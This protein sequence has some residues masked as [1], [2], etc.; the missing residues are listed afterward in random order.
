METLL[1]ILALAAV[2]LGI[3]T[4]YGS[5]SARIRRALRGA[6]RVSIAEAPEGEVVRID[7]RVAEGE[8]LEAPLT[9]RRCVYY[10]A[11][12]EEKGDAGDWMEVVR[13]SGGVR[14]MVEDGTG[15]AIIDPEGARINVDLDSTTRSGTIDEPTSRETAFLARHRVKGIGLFF[16]RTLRYRE[17]V[18]EIG[19]PI[20]V[21]CQPVRE[22]DPDAASRTAGYRDLPPTRLRVGGSSARPIRLSDSRDV[23]QRSRRR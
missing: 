7:G 4:W 16:N 2:P 17:G 6:R 9:G 15:H 21:M 18:F 5:G 22:P 12:V 1:L 23:T 20:A 13:E 3:A 10:V 14:F 19:E 8:A 11:V